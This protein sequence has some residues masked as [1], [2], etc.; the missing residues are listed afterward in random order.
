MNQARFNLA[1]KKL[2]IGKFQVAGGA[3]NLR[4]D[5][6][7]G[8]NIAKI[9]RIYPERNTAEARPLE[10][11]AKAA[12]PAPLYPPW[13]VDAD[14]IEIKDIAFDFDN[15][16]RATPVS[17][18]VSSIGISFAAKIQ[19][20]TQKTKV[21]L[22][23][24]SS[25][26]T[27][28]HIQLLEATQPIFQTDK[29]TIEGGMLD[30]EAHSLSV[31]RIAMHG[32]TIDVSRDSKGQINWQQLLAP[33]QSA[34]DTSVSATVRELQPSWNYRIMDFEVD[35]FNS[36]LSDLGIVPDKPILNI[37]S[38]SGRLTEVDGKS[39]MNFEADFWLKQGGTVAVRGKVDP[40]AASVE[41]NVNLKAMSLTP[42]QPYLEP[43]AKVSLQSADVSL[44][45]DLKYGLEAAG[46]KIIYTGN[47]SL[48]KLQLNDPNVNKTLIGWESIKAPQVK[49]TLQPNNLN[50]EEI[51]LSKPTGE[52]II[53]QDQTLNLSSVFK[54]KDSQTITP[55][56]PK[57]D[58]KLDQEAF[59]VRIGKIDIEKGDM[60]F[61]DLSLQPQF[62][63]RINDLKGRISG[64]SSAGDLPSTV[65]LDGRV[66]QY[67]LAKISGKINVFNPGLSTDLSLLF[68]NVEMTKLTPYSGR[69][70]GRRITSGKLSMDL[71]YRI[72]DHKLLGDN[73]II[74]DN[75]TLGERL[76]S[77]VAVNL[78]LDLAIALLQDSNGRIDIGLP[79][80]GDLNDPQF[81]YGH[82]V[83]KTIMNFLTKIVTS[84]F[85]ALGGVFGG[86]GEQQDIVVFDPGKSELLPPEKEKL[87][88]MGDLLKNRPLLRLNVQG[89]F[90][91]DADG[92]EIKAQ[93]VRLAIVGRTGSKSG[94]KEDLGALD[95]TA[96]NTQ[97]ALEKLFIEKAGAPAF[98]A[99][100]LSI[101][102]GAK[103]KADV[104]QVL[105]EALYSWLLDNEPLSSEALLMLAENRAIEIIKELSTVGG[106][107][108]ER[109][110]LKTPEPQT[111]GSP[112]A[113]FSLDAL[114][115]SQ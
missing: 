113:K 48:D 69:F 3:V 51:L 115:A 43:F 93:S 76:E 98:D 46:A 110:S 19:A 99:L 10:P 61:A 20:G 71:K 75:L 45:G 60:I 95:F 50:I 112:S 39:P 70:A 24:F 59:P 82:L 6:A 103:N 67:G 100:K 34:A 66:N 102:K 16:S 40:A 53:K 18:G 77:P 5:E 25:E 63:T 106:I 96:P 47:A 83:W 65:Q 88:K 62:M 36:D 58:S 85:R 57:S 89:Q 37:Q 28:A 52:V 97:R 12:P 8:I 81:S 84:P 86:E 94:E 79:V 42:L 92:A 74:V 72:Q 90:S 111:S 30:L 80:S 7:G 14:S 2:L 26:L 17:T 22:E 109:L 23:N 68:K 29:L 104:P 21:L 11:T 114:T 73:Q 55:A 49:L 33:K 31:S 54:S 91:P 27:E 35:G 41:A 32:G 38:F 108:S 107:P 105:A 9:A 44:H 101:E 4:I 56:S 64:L 1:E 13:T 15:F 87:H 78:P